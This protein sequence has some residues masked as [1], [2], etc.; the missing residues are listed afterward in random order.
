[1][2]NKALYFVIGGIVGVFIVRG[3]FFDTLEGI[4]WRLFWEGV[5]RGEGMN[6]ETILNSA[7]FAKTLAG[8]LIGGMIATFIDH[9]IRQPSTATLSPQVVKTIKI[10][11]PRRP[12]VAA[13]LTI[14]TRGLGH[15]YTGE[16]KRGFILFGIEQFIVV[17]FAVLVIV[18]ISGI[19]F[20]ILAAVGGFAFTVF[21][22]AD[23]VRIARKKKDYY[24]LA[25]Y[26]R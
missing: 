14:V 17:I 25:K 3:F 13:L 18:V 4:G 23:A 10:I 12:W 7:T 26:N 20:L 16:P 15:L 9:K 22:V 6:L 1:M 5:K 24:E 19:T 8:F 21:C 2:K 11:K